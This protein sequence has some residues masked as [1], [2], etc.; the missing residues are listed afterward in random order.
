MFVSGVSPLPRDPHV[1]TGDRA[2]GRDDD[3]FRVNPNHSVMNESVTVLAVAAVAVLAGAGLIALSDSDTVMTGYAVLDSP[4]N[5]QV[6]QVF[7]DEFLYGNMVRVSV[8]TITDTDGGITCRHV[9]DTEYTDYGETTET[10]DYF[11][12]GDSA[13]DFDYTDPDQ[14]PDGFT[15]SEAGGVYTINGSNDYISFE[16]LKVAYDGTSVTSVEGS[17]RIDSG[18]SQVTYYYLTDGGV[19]KSR[20]IGHSEITDTYVT[21]GFIEDMAP[22]FDPSILSGPDVVQTE[23]MLNGYGVTVYT[24]NG[25]IGDGKAEDLKIYV[26]NGRVVRI[27]GIF[28]GSV[29]YENLTITA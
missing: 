10:L 12:P 21:E 28:S 18:P 26:Y 27:D 23:E 4:D 3:Y 11:A 13:I 24:V 29:Y 22:A 5:L 7:T 8:Y 6:G 19:L 17:L 20:G 15:V 1:I 25:D 16:D 14:V 2:T 9:V